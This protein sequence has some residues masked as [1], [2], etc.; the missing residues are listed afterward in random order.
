[1][2]KA[3]NLHKIPALQEIHVRDD[4]KLRPLQDSDDE[5]LL[6]ILAAD[7]SIREKVTVASRFHKPEDIAAE[8]ENYSKNP[9]LIRYTLVKGENPIGLVSLW[10]D[11]GYFGTSP[12]PSDYGFG[13]FLDPMERG[14]GLVNSALQSLKKAVTKNLQ[15]NQFVAFCEDQNAES[16]AV[17]TKL[18]FKPT[19][20]TFPEP[21]NGWIER[22]YINPVKKE[23]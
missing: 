23:F 9:S 15:V 22:K 1:M 4:V 3:T 18:G 20:K 8:V 21:I 2:S 12:Q 19:D 17:L 11:E 10:R 6:E 5:R 7:N 13:Y 16:V 14:K